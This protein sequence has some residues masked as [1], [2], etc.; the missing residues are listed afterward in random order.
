MNRPDLVRMKP[1][2]PSILVLQSWDSIQRDGTDR[3]VPSSGGIAGLADQSEFPKTVSWGCMTQ[4]ASKLWP[5]S[6]STFKPALL[7][8]RLRSLAM[9]SLLRLGHRA[10]CPGRRGSKKRFRAVPSALHSSRTNSLSSCAISSFV[11]IHSLTAT[12]VMLGSWQMS[13]CGNWAGRLSHGGARIGCE[14]GTS[15]AD[16]SMRF[17][18][19]TRMTCSRSKYLH[20]REAGLRT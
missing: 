17:V 6:S 16:T 7:A 11:F 18:P 4:L 9:E 8:S 12:V 15:G 1:H 3:L 2:S 20:A 19:R 14:P 5:L 13:S 10:G